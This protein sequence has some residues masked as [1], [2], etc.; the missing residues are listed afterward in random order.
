MDD[1]S[2]VFLV[3]F[4]LEA[5]VKLTGLGMSYFRDSWNNFDLLIC[6]TGDIGIVMQFFSSNSDIANVVVVFRALRICRMVRLVKFSH[7]FKVLV[8][9]ITIIFASVSNIFGLI[10]LDL[11]VFGILGLVLFHKVMLQEHYNEVYNF[12]SFGSSC[13]LLIRCLTGENWPKIMDEIAHVQSYGGI[14]CVDN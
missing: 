7:D 13:L 5:A 14:E 11:F 3:I 10:A 9:S 6:A 2:L 4:N 12:R 8:N 1:L